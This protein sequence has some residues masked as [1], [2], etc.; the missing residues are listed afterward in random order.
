[1]ALTR[2]GAA[3]LRDLEGTAEPDRAV[4]SVAV[5][6]L[7]RL[8]SSG[9]SFDSLRSDGGND[10]AADKEGSR[11]V[12]TKACDDGLL[13]NVYNA[14]ARQLRG[15]GDGFQRSG[16]PW[17]GDRCRSASA[18]GSGIMYALPSLL[19]SIGPAE[20]AVW[21]VQAILSVL[22]DYV[23]IHHDSAWHG[24]DRWFASFNALRV[25]YL[26]F[27][28]VRPALAILLSVPP[29]LSFVAASRAKTDGGSSGATRTSRIDPTIRNVVSASNW[30]SV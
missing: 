1:M 18:G 27:R 11:R 15:L 20:R 9:A 17:D 21:I 6:K 8:H 5:P 13:G 25:V 26:G 24:I 3:R 30:A 2:A 7:R 22:A 16:L 12:R 29:I 4:E 23:H 10:V 28:V 14:L 19:L